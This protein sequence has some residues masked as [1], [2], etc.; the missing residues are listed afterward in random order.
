M[1]VECQGLEG[2]EMQACE[3]RALGF[4]IGAREIAFPELMQFK[5]VTAVWDMLNAD[6]RQ[7]MRYLD[8]STGETIRWKDMSEEQQNDVADRYL[9]QLEDSLARVSRRN[10]PGAEQDEGPAPPTGYANFGMTPEFARQIP[11]DSRVKYDQGGYILNDGGT[12]KRVDEDWND[13]E[14]E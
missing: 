8:R 7:S 3:R 14:A 1:Q 6:D 9:Q 4:V 10:A 11:V 12:L 13:W 2:D 5:N